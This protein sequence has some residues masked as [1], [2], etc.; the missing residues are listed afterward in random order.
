MSLGRSS[1]GCGCSRRLAVSAGVGISQR[2]AF[3]RRSGDLLEE[4]D[5][6]VRRSRGLPGV[7]VGEVV[8]AV[9][10]SAAVAPT[11]DTTVHPRSVAPVDG[12]RP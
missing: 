7:K 12:P 4:I 11:S 8:D 6:L 1:G 3:D 5:V 9:A 2:L 10:Y